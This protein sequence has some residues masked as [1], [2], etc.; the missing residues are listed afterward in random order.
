MVKEEA[1][2]LH[3]IDLQSNIGFYPDTALKVLA[4][5][6]MS[7]RDK[8]KTGEISQEELER[9]KASHG[10]NPYVPK[11]ILVPIPFVT[12]ELEA[13]DQIE[14]EMIAEGSCAK[15][16]TLKGGG[17]ANGCPGVHKK[18]DLLPQL[19]ALATVIGMSVLSSYAASEMPSYEQQS[20]NGVRGTIV[21]AEAFMQLLNEEDNEG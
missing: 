18:G 14:A 16:A 3:D 21:D 1:K 2:K 8:I 4:A 12:T 5:A 20:A 15:C 6:A 7:L 11:S 13:L 10:N 19:L 9:I 17:G